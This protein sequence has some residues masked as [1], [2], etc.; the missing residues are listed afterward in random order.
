MELTILLSKIF[1]VYMIVAGL[2]VF[3]NRKH[4]MAGIIGMAKERFAQIMAGIIGL[5][6]GLVMVNIHNDWSTLPASLISLIGWAGLVKGLAYLFLPEKSLTKLMH[7]F[8]ERSWYLIDGII[9][10]VVG[11]YLAGFGYGWF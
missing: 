6:F 3:M 11:I 1:G 2:A 7:L 9:V 10:L 4:L 5:L 8:T